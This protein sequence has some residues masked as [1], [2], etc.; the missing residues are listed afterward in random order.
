MSV[1]NSSKIIVFCPHRRLRM[2]D[3]FFCDTIYEPGMTN[4]DSCWRVFIFL[5][6][7][8]IDLC[9][10]ITYKH[11]FDSSLFETCRAARLKLHSEPISDTFFVILSR[12]D[13]VSS[14]KYRR[15]YAV[16]HTRNISSRRRRLVEWHSG[17]AYR[18]RSPC[19]NI[20]RSRAVHVTRLA[21]F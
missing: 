18:H 11:N 4:K 1:S 16:S 8:K 14:E 20:L 12:H 7:K 3:R 10:N 9:E 2:C 13:I 5:E 17:T 21:V 6:I 15:H 19:Q